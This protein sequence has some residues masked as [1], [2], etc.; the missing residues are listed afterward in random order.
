M[1]QNSMDIQ[2]GAKTVEYTDSNGKVYKS[3]TGREN[4]GTYR[5]EYNPKVAQYSKMTT[6]QLE[7]ELKKQRE[8]SDD[9]YQRFTRQAASRSG[10][11]VRSMTN[12]DEEIRAIR[13]VLSRRKRK[14]KEGGK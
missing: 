5:T 9:N 3:E 14:H 4:G 8:V 11:L 12:A 6:Q 10:S 1:M 13:Q 7:N 2:G